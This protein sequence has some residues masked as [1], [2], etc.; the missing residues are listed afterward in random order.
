MTPT[1][2]KLLAE[3]TNPVLPYSGKGADGVSVLG[4][5]IS[6][7]IDGMFI[8]GF[9]IALVYLITGGFH[10]ITSAGDKGNLENARNKII[11]AIVGLIVLAS[12]WAIMTLVGSFIGLDFQKLPIPSLK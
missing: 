1:H 10:W 7:I 5:L 6:N 11:H 12:A 3:I 2:T 4:K 8:M 9:L